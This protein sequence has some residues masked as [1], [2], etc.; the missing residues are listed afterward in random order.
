MR[1]REAA[2]DDVPAIARVTVDTW[3]TAYRGIVDDG[4]LDNL[5]YEERE[6]GWRQF[7]FH[8]SFAYVAED[9]AQNIIGFA[10]AGPER[11]GNP[12]YRGELYAF[13]IYQEEQNKGVGKALFLSVLRKLE[14]SG[15]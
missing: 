4:Y 6:K 3:K 12:E 8:D 13:Y 14:E 15:I 1:I 7:P 11:E 5:T 10:A 9:E 2:A